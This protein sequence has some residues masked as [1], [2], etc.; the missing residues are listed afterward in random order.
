MRNGT[1]HVPEH[2]A[3]LAALAQEV[4][5]LRDLFQR[6][7]FEDKS[8][9]RLYDQVCAE[10]ASA[11]AELAAHS[12]APLFRELLLLVDRLD[13]LH[14][15]GDEALGSV[16]DEIVEILE[17]R[18]VR[19]VPSRAVFD[20]TVH[21]AVRAEPGADRPT[22]TIIEVI[23]PGYLIGSRLLRAERV[24]VATTAAPSN[25]SI[26]PVPD[27]PAVEAGP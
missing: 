12:A 20:P 4:A 23:R 5:Q 26:T 22:G 10:L 21:E 1:R 13:G 6:R 15:D 24:V 9:N 7:L 3:S 19:R 27:D 14:R 8:K 18:D 25:E 17:R 2:D 16:R 11:R